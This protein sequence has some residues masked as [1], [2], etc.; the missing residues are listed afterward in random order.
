MPKEL[1]K[2]LWQTIQQGNVF[3]GIIKN[4]A[5]DGTHYWVDATIVPMK[6]EKGVI[7]KFVGARYHI[8]D[9]DLGIALYNKQADRLKWPRL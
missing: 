6:N 7:T 8:K 9:D 3:S 2:L 4:K 1:Y 5:K